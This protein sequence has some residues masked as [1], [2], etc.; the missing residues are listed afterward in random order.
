MSFRHGIISESFRIANRRLAF[1]LAAIIGQFAVHL[2]EETLISNIGLTF[3]SAIIWSMLAFI[4]HSECLHAPEDQEAMDIGRV[5]GFAVR[6]VCLTAMAAIPS[7]FLMSAF[8]VSQDPELAAGAYLVAIVPTFALAGI[9]V[10]A[11]FGTILPGYVA[12]ERDS[13]SE[14]LRCGSEQFV[15]IAVRLLLSAFIG[16]TAVALLVAPVIFFGAAGLML[17]GGYTPN[18]LVMPFAL[19]AYTLLAWSIILTAVIL[20]RAYLRYANAGMR[21]LPESSEEDQPTFSI[22]KLR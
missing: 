21:I 2:A 8:P 3:A 18:P 5:F 7:V 15:W 16:I 10:F 12:E 14:A 19:V 13:I 1:I 6:A 22:G 4:A 11:L 9:F 20:S 17:S